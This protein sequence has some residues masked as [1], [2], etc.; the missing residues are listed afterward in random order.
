V[1]ESPLSEAGF[2]RTVDESQANAGTEGHHATR[3]DNISHVA[4]A[5]LVHGGHSFDMDMTIEDRVRALED[6]VIV[7]S[8]IVE[9]RVGKYNEANVDQRVFHWGSLIH[10]WAGEVTARRS[11][12]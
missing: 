7:L 11:K 5:R 12:S 10:Q 2:N 1:V 3:H 6:V 4:V 9:V 8:N